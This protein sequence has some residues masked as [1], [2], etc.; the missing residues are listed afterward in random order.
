MMNRNF[1]NALS[2]SEVLA[3]HSSEES[4]A[5]TYICWKTVFHLQ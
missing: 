2:N 4:V 5:V 3:R 1:K